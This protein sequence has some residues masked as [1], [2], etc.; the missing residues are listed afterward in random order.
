MSYLKHI[1]TES[2]LI[3]S[4]NPL[5]KSRVSEYFSDRESYL[6]E[7]AVW[8]VSYAIPEK[9]EVNEIGALSFGSLRNAELRLLWACKEK[10]KKK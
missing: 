6:F 8:H 9:N 1:C 10:N 7:R 3:R 2:K 4:T 5:E